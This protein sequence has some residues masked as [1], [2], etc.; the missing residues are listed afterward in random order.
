MRPRAPRSLKRFVA[1][2]L[3]A[4]IG[5]GLPAAYALAEEEPPNQTVDENA[6]VVRP[7]IFPI[8][9]GGTFHDDFG[10]PR[11]GGT[12]AHAGND[13]AAPKHSLAVAVVDGVIT[14]VVHSN[15]GNAGNM[16]VITDAEGWTY[17]YIHL[18][19]DTPGTDDNANDPAFAFAEGIAVGRIVHAGDP[20]GYV[21]DSGNAEDSTPHIHFEIRQPDHTPVNPFYSLSLAAQDPATRIGYLCR[22]LAAT[23]TNSAETEPIRASVPVPVSASSV[24]LTQLGLTRPG[25]DD[26]NERLRPVRVVTPTP[27]PT[28]TPTPKPTP[29]PAPAVTPDQAPSPSTSEGPIYSPRMSVAAIS[30]A[31]FRGALGDIQLEMAELVDIVAVEGNTGFLLL[32]ASGEVQEFGSATYFGGLDDLDDS[33]VAAAIAA[34]ATGDGYWI[35]EA[36]GR[37]HAFGTAATFE[38]LDVAVGEVGLVDMTATADGSG[39]FVLLSDGSVR[40]RGTATDLGGLGDRIAPEPID[41]VAIEASPEG[42]GYWILNADGRVFTFGDVSF[43]GSGLGG[44]R[45]EWNETIGT[46]SGLAGRALWVAADDLQLWPFGVAPQLDPLRPVASES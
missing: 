39:L 7:I 2:A 5:V 24:E 20:V 6:P 23:F 41:P 3:T 35:A 32:D 37:L 4:A 17:V 26:D 19:N 21:G 28:E 16:L 42:V 13:V 18:N 10:D 33:G 46:V 1:V 34:T 45:C 14:N 29:T 25:D 43:A 36:D 11:G 40:V 30:D 38:D 9:S 12:R 31:G 27:A 44:S 22:G 15:D 8:P